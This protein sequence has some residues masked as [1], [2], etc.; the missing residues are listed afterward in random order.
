MGR[1]G[2]QGFPRGFPDP[3][4]TLAG[5]KGR[6]RFWRQAWMGLKR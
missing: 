2:K 3:S 5:L 4:V 1:G 6:A